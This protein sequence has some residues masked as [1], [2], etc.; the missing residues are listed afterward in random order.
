M[1]DAASTTSPI[2]VSS[3]NRKPETKSSRILAIS[4]FAAFIITVVLTGLALNHS[5]LPV[6]AIIP[7][8]S[9]PL[10]IALLAMSYFQKKKSEESD[11]VVPDRS[12][13]MEPP[14]S[15]VMNATKYSENTG[16]VTSLVSFDLKQ[17]M[18][19]ADLPFGPEKKA[20]PIIGQR[21][22]DLFLDTILLAIRLPDASLE[23]FP[24]SI[25]TILKKT[26]DV[27]ECY[28]IV[29]DDSAISLDET[30]ERELFFHPYAHRSI[31]DHDGYKKIAVTADMGIFTQQGIEVFPD[32]MPVNSTKPRKIEIVCSDSQFSFSSS[33]TRFI[34]Q[35]LR[36]VTSFYAV[37]NIP[38]GK[39]AFF[40]MMIHD[41]ASSEGKA[42]TTALS[43]ETLSEIIT[44]LEH[45]EF[46]MIDTYKDLI[47]F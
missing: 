23:K 16:G 14:N 43:C 20:L 8:F 10:S 37:A 44:A 1:I 38:R 3:T 2:S 46:P 24:E 19:I 22:G 30:T 39:I 12:I 9:F 32:G 31:Q 34:I 35:D 29:Y 40:G 15:P 47:G 33:K 25:Q 45:S 6:S 18:T 28:I 27:S 7:V 42:L 13:N 41:L 5:L 4:S 17:N 36:K 26:Q 11:G 21:N